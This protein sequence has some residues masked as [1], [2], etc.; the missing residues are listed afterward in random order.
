MLHTSNIVFYGI[1]KGGFGWP[2]GGI[3]DPGV[4]DDIRHC[5]NPK[6]SQK[7]SDNI[8]VDLVKFFNSWPETGEKALF[9]IS[10]ATMHPVSTQLFGDRYSFE[11]CPHLR[12]NIV[13]FDVEVV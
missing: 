3:D 9:D 8:G 1:L 2:G 10:H 5:L 13:E 12:K 6:A 11:Q 4:L 7:F